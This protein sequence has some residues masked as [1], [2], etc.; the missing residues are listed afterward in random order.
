LLE[1]AMPA[2]IDTPAEEAAWQK[3]KGIV[4]RQRKK[5]EEDFADKDWGLVTHIA[6]NLLR[7]VAVSGSTRDEGT[8]YALANVER[9]LDTR[10]KRER[11]QR[12][13]ALS[14]SDQSLVT[15][16]SQ[17]AALGGQTISALRDARESNLSASD[18]NTLTLELQ[19]VATRLRDVLLKVKG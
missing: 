5:K 7:A 11:R 4:A 6:K 17:V 13:T 10:R 14:A 16:L 3:A 9:L 2:W 18:N 19:A 8:V 12:D 1:D 15:A